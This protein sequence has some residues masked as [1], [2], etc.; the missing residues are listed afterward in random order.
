MDG[1]ATERGRSEKK[2]IGTYKSLGG[3]FDAFVVSRPHLKSKDSFVDV[4]VVYVEFDLNFGA[5]A[6]LGCPGS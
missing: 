3:P 1:R 6:R 2:V 5:E 4:L